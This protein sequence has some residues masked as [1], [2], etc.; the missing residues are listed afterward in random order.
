MN[1]TDDMRKCTV[2]EII[3][4]KMAVKEWVRSKEKVRDPVH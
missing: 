4:G 1:S 2:E 3:K